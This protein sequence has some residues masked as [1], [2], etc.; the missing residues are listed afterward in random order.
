MVIYSWEIIVM[1]EKTEQDRLL[2]EALYLVLEFEL[3]RLPLSGRNFRKEEA[4]LLL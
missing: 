3:L 1:T 2:E 4:L